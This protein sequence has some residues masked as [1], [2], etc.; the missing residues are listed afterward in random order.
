M[1]ADRIVWSP[2]LTRSRPTVHR[3][4]EACWQGWTTFVFLSRKNAVLL[5][6]RFCRKCWPD[7][8]EK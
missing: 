4:G 5:D 7:Q 6:A 2:D 1:T 8:K 3:C